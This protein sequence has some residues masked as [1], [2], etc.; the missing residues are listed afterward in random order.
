MVHSFLKFLADKDFT[1]QLTGGIALAV[2]HCPGLAMRRLDSSLR[3]HR[4][5]RSQCRHAYSG[6]NKTSFASVGPNSLLRGHRQGTTDAVAKSNLRTSEDKNLSGRINARRGHRLDGTFVSR[7]FSL[8]SA[9]LSNITNI[10]PYIVFVRL[11]GLLLFSFPCSCLVGIL[12]MIRRLFA[13]VQGSVSHH[14]IDDTQQPS[15]HGDVGLGFADSFYESLADSLLV[16]VGFAESNRCLADSPSQSGR[17]RLCDLA[18]L[19][20]SGGFLVVGSDSGPELEGI[21]VWEPVEG[22]NLGGYDTGPDFIYAGYAFE[23]GNARGEFITS[24]GEY[25]LSPERFTLTLDKRNDINK[26]GK[27]RPLD[28]FEQMAVGKEPLLS[29]GSTELWAADIGG[30][31]YR[32]HAVFGSGERFAELS[33]VSSELSELHKGLVGDKSERTVSSY[34]PDSDIA[35][36]VFVVLPAFTSSCCQFGGVCY[37]DPVDAVSVAVDKPFYETDGL[38]RHPSGSGQGIDPVFD[39]VDALGVNGQRRNDVFF[40]V[41]CTKSD[42]GFMEIDADER[43]EVSFGYIPALGET[44]SLFCLNVLHNKFLKRGQ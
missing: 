3:S 18:G 20:S 5:W 13:F 14:G 15:A 1:R 27:R 35:G 29:G 2:R 34:E 10:P 44:L 6:L 7:F 41:G 31:K 39:L 11:S 30:I 4:A 16:G 12:K 21:G 37:V 32:F 22:S 19:S 24:I 17:T 28:I 40:G 23:Y 36:I 8:I 9:K 42:S 33:P 43:S 26:V 25:D 38:D